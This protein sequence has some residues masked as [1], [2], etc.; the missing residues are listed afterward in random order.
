QCSTFRIVDP[1]PDITRMTDG[2]NVI[3]QITS[4]Q[5]DHAGGAKRC[6]SNRQQSKRLTGRRL[7][8]RNK[9]LAVDSIDHRLFVSVMSWPVRRR[10]DGSIRLQQF[11][12]I[13]AGAAGQG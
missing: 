13:D 3:L 10:D 1:Q 5:N 7:D 11:K 6:L 8:P 4:R 2:R 12:K 9:W